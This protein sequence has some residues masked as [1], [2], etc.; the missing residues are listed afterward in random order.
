MYWPVFV[1][2][3]IFVATGL[4]KDRTGSFEVSSLSAGAI[5][6]I[7]AMTLNALG[8]SAKWSLATATKMQAALVQTPLSNFAN[9][10]SI[11]LAII[12]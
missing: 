12:E 11:W 3:R 5:E 10:S 1:V 9:R 4:M 7:A 8:E 6:M 2:V